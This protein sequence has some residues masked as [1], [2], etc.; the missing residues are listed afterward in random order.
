[1]A[2]KEETVKVS[3]TITVQENQDQILQEDIG[4]GQ[5][6]TLHS[7]T[8]HSYTMLWFK[9]RVYFSSFFQSTHL[10]WY[11]MHRDS[12]MGPMEGLLKELE[13]LA[14][15]HLLAL[16]FPPDPSYIW[17]PCT[18]MFFLCYSL[19][20]WSHIHPSGP[21]C[22]LVFTPFQKLFPGEYQ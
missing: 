7:V 13:S 1:M 4:Y 20:S 2:R 12:I 22:F 6:F 16:P 9:A 8:L 21:D 17:I 10:E 18:V 14:C 5:K 19:P 3:A 11:M 15:S